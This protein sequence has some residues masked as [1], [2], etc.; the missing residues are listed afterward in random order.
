MANQEDS[1][2]CNKSSD[3]KCLIKKNASIVSYKIRARKH[4]MK[5]LRSEEKC[6]KN[7]CDY[8]TGLTTERVKEVVFERPNIWKRVNDEHFNSEMV[9]NERKFQNVFK[10]VITSFIGNKRNPNHTVK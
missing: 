1:G 9:I 3:N 4:F 6:F 8:F 5:A 10:L 7:V 2:P